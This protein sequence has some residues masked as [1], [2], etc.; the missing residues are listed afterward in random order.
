MGMLSPRKP[1][2]GPLAD[3]PGYGIEF[4]LPSNI[5][6]GLYKSLRQ[7]G[8]NKSPWLGFAVMSRSEL[9]RERGI[10]KFNAM[11]KPST[12]ILI[13]NVFKPS[14]ATTA[15]I[16]PGDFLVQFDGKPVLSPLNFQRYLYLTGIGAKVTLKMYRGGKLFD[17]EAKIEERPKNASQK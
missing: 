14:P 7:T 5:L 11:D 12:G 1:V 15:G 17:V 4:A 16:Q 10:E 6:Q 3:L 9:I 2:P 8:G 13:E